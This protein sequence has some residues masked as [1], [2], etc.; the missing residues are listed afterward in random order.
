[1]Q[2][3]ASAEKY[4]NVV[5][6]TLR[7]RLDVFGAEQLME[8]FNALLREG[9]VHFIVD[10]TPV[11]VVDADGDYPLLHL[12]KCAQEVGGSVSLVCPAGNPIRVYYEMMRLDTLF[13]MQETLEVAVAQ[14]EISRN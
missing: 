5:V 4:D 2:V 11:R 8:E 6:V 7:E 14:F 13:D 9:A 12:L 1:M 3:I 10:L